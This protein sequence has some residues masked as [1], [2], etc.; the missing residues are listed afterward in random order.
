MSSNSLSL[1]IELDLSFIKKGLKQ[2]E[3]KVKSTL[4]S[5]GQ[6]PVILDANGQPVMDAMAEIEG[7]IEA[8]PDGAVNIEADGSQVY[9]YLK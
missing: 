2:L 7:E 4:E 9:V 5:I 8:L 6:K 1:Q 3:D